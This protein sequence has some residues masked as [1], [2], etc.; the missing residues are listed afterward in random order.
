MSVERDTHGTTVR[1]AFLPLGTRFHVCDTGFEDTIR[2]VTLLA[3]IIAA[4]ETVLPLWIFKRA[5]LPFYQVRKPDRSCEVRSA[6]NLLPKDTFLSTRHEIGGRN[7]IIFVRWSAMFVA[8]V[9][10]LTSSER[11]ILLICDE[12]R[13]H[14]SLQCLLV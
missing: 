10:H 5:C 14:L 6:A 9:Q 13:S 8:R 7:R 12:P 11:N 4:S 2:H 3:T 1:E